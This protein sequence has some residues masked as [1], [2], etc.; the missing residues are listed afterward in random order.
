MTTGVA[1]AGAGTAG[2]AGDAG[3]AATIVSTGGPAGIAAAGGGIC[4]GAG[5]GADVPAGEQAAVIST[6]AQAPAT[7]RQPDLSSCFGG[8]ISNFLTWELLFGE[9]SGLAELTRPLRA[10]GGRRVR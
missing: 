7:C 3:A 1:A 5:T 8:V 9:C 10:A 6:A 2:T 4:S